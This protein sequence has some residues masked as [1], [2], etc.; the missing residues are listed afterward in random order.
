[1]YRKRESIRYTSSDFCGGFR[2]TIAEVLKIITNKLNGVKTMEDEIEKRKRELYEAVEKCD[3]FY[4]LDF[5]LRMI[6]DLT[7]G[8]HS[9]EKAAC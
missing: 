9:N 2:Q 7:L 1:M 5:M 6:N 4:I 8:L 3:D